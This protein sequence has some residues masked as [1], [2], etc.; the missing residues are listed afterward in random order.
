MALEVILKMMLYCGVTAQEIP[1]MWIQD[2]QDKKRKIKDSIPSYLY[3]DTIDITPVKNELDHY[4]QYLMQNNQPFIRKSPLFPTFP[5]YQAI[6]RAISRLDSS[7]SIEII[8][9]IARQNGFP[10]RRTRL[11]KKRRVAS[12]NNCIKRFFEITS[13]NDYRKKKHRATLLYRKIQHI[14]KTDLSEHWNIILKSVQK[15]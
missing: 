1:F 7:F 12:Y 11:M 5:R 4:V 15:I 14:R 10:I 9:E 8:H 2:V 6:Q 3:I 13:I